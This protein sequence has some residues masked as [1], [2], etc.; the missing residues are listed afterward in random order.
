MSAE[1]EAR[2]LIAVHPGS[3]GAVAALRGLDLEVGAGEIVAIVGPSGSGKTTLLRLLAAIDRP[4]AGS[5]VVHGLDLERASPGAIRHH[6]RSVVATVDQHYRRAVSPYLPIGEIVALPLAVR[7]VAVGDRRARASS[8]LAALGLAGRED[9]RLG[10]LSGGEQQR[11]AVAAALAIRP[12]RGSPIGWWSSKTVAPW[13]RERARRERPSGRSSTP[14]VG[15]P[16]RP[17]GGSGW[18]RALSR[19]RPPRASRAGP[20]DRAP[21]RPRWCFAGSR[22]A[23]GRPA[24]P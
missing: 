24:R 12:W 2:G 4:T 16:R 14:A 3:G 10:D 7:N 21:A 17:R 13:P 1:I 9:A 18:T 11:V 6:R 22:A 8:L 15:G 23:T 19:D 20:T 5:L